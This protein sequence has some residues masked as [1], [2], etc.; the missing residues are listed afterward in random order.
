VRRLPLRLSPVDGEG[1]PGYIA[2][3]SHTFQFQP[4]D[5]VRALGLDHGTGRV[6]AAGRYG[7]SLT[8]DQLMHAAFATGIGV[9]VLEGMLLSRY[10]GRAFDRSALTA[11]VALAGPVQGHEVRTRSSRFC[12]QCLGEDDAWRLRWQLGW[13]A[14][15]TRHQVVL[16]GRCPKCEAV[17][18]IARSRRARAATS[19]VTPGG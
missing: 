7:V 13:S 15:C 3:Y 1:L 5:V 2:R 16:V 8:S 17:S 18:T 10:A 19:G 12:P 4:G 9:E 14:I 11:P 6:A